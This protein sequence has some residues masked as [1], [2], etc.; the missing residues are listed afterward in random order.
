MIYSLHGEVADG[1]EHGIILQC[2]PVSYELFCS[3]RDSKEL[4]DC[5]GQG[6]RTV[7][8]SLEVDENELVLLGFYSRES[9]A[10]YRALITLHG[11]GRKIA[12]N[13]LNGGEAR[14]IICAVL[15]GDT[16]FLRGIPQL[17]SKRA[18][19][20]IKQLRKSWTGAPPRALPVGLQEWVQARDVLVS[21]GLSVDDA[22]ERLFAELDTQ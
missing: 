15:S 9:Q 22:E 4:L 7:Y 18:D 2:G 6:E 14:D 8:T 3:H 11:V 1:W 12:M 13:V 16:T 10:L 19:N 21:K 17:G 20:L 5:V